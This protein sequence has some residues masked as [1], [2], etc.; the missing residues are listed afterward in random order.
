MVA[1][2]LLFLGYIGAGVLS[3][4]LVHLIWPIQA[5]ERVTGPCTTLA[6]LVWF[7]SNPLYSFLGG[8]L[9]AHYSVLAL[10]GVSLL[11]QYLTLWYLRAK[12]DLRVQHG[13]AIT[14]LIAVSE[15][16]LSQARETT[17]NQ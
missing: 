15:E 10:W 9:N 12:H 17:D 4:L 1:D 14:P 11:L 6:F 2:L 16:L 8:H 7:V 5:P 3:A 13:S